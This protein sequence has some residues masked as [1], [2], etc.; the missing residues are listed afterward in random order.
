[1]TDFFEMEI[2][3]L[4]TA[5]EDTFVMI[6]D[7]HREQSW[8]R[9]VKKSEHDVEFEQQKELLSMMRSIAYS[10]V[11][12][13]LNNAVSRLRGSRIYNNN[14]KVQNWMEKYWLPEIKCWAKVY[15]NKVAALVI[16]TNNGIERQNKCL[17]YDYIS[18]YSDKS[19]NGLL[20]LIRDFY[21]PDAYKKY[22][23]ST[24]KLSSSYRK[25]NDNIPE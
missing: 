14:K 17:K 22:I 12:L 19:L 7:F 13:A 11:V 21:L 10:R 25:Y 23:Q 18:R 4:N 20:T 1:M 24:L 8:E 5:F 6:C 3:A 2:N 9:W 15:R 16:N